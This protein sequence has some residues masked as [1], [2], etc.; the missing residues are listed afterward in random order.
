MRK[1]RNIVNDK[2]SMSI[3]IIKE[4]DGSFTLRTYIRNWDEEESVEYETELKPHPASRFADSEDAE[5][6]ARRLL[7]RGN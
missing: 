4:D 2:N 1:V 7:G 5:K 6:E 3:C